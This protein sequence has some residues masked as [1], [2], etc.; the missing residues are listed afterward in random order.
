MFVVKNSLSV[1][2]N[3]AGQ[4]FEYPGKKQRS[5]LYQCRQATQSYSCVCCVCARYSSYDCGKR[6][7]KPISRLRI[8]AFLLS[9]RPHH[10][11]GLRSHAKIRK[12]MLGNR[13]HGQSG[14]FLSS[15]T[16][17][18]SERTGFN[19][20]RMPCWRVSSCRMTPLC[21]VVGCQPGIPCNHS[22]LNQQD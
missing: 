22:G 8:R 2:K 21:H 3:L 11:K 14:L 19:R 15:R 4:V 13:T 5:E 1:K 16:A 6:D 20:Q 7:S 10:R 9:S 18:A 12:Y 17:T